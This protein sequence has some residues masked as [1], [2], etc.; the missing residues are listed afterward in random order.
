MSGKQTLTT[1]P[2]TEAGNPEPDRTDQE[3]LAA[4]LQHLRDLLE[5]DRVPEARRFVKELEQRWPEAERVQHYA[6][7]LEPPKVRMR[8]DLPARSSEREV[9]WV[10]DHARE[11][12]GCWLAIHEDRLIA[13]DPDLQV[14]ITEAEQALGRE[15]YL[16][17]YQPGNGPIK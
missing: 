1:L 4:D 15:T 14:V 3:Q 5:A 12:P 2:Q 16:M 11:Y 10:K 17:F 9:Q 8:P 13:A 6:R 7:V